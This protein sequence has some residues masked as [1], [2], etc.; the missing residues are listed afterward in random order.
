MPQKNT[1]KLII[2]VSAG[3]GIGIIT[4]AM[5]VFLMSA[6]L[7]VGN[8]P[9]MLISPVTV[10]FLAI[11][12]FC[13]GFSSARLMEEKGIICGGI[14]GLLFFIIVWV[15]GAVL[16]IS[17][18]GTA[19]IIKALMMIISSSLGGIIGVNYIKRK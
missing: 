18:T 14:S 8:I 5:L 13:G 19:A 11:G 1:K 15:S 10:L 17:G 7:A 9:A 12:S 6:A 16:D 4:C 3:T 2:S